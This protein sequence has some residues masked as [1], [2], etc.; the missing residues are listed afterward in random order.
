[1]TPLTP[2]MSRKDSTVSTETIEEQL[3]ET[4]EHRRAEALAAYRKM[5]HKFA[6]K[7][8]S[9]VDV[10]ALADIAAKAGFD[11][12]TVGRH[13]RTVPELRRLEREL[14]AATGVDLNALKQKLVDAS[15]A[16]H[17]K[18]MGMVSQLFDHGP[19][20]IERTATEIGLAING[21]LGKA[22][23]D[24]RVRLL[25]ARSMAILAKA[26]PPYVPPPKQWP[27]TDEVMQPVKDAQRALGEATARPEKIR[28]EIL[29]LRRANSELFCD[30]DENA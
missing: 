5:V 15:E 2:A 18:L 22:D 29:E 27:S 21:G 11:D 14:D 26:T 30:D 23:N 13:L 17:K 24:E 25:S 10:P 16:A 1:M 19:D 3:Q 12:A 20:G 8:L 4:R 7:E 6:G 28:G 9:G